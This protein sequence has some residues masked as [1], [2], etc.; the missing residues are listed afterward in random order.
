[1]SRRFAKHDAEATCHELL[2]GV[3]LKRNFNWNC[4]ATDKFSFSD[5]EA[6][7]DGELVAIV[8]VKNRR[9]RIADYPT[10]HVSE[11]KLYRCL[12]IAEQRSCGFV[13]AV[14]CETGLYAVSLVRF[15]VDRMNR[16]T[17]GRT[18]RGLT[19]D[20][21]QLVEIPTELFFRL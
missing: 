8:E 16:K 3:A 1:M 2:V 9:I 6:R 19:N 21:E 17:G 18:D 12:D 13:F 14:S 4:T 15:A 10:I 20:I 7:K 5:L 11:K